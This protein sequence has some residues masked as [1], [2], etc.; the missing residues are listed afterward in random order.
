[1]LLA[2]VTLAVAALR[3]LELEVMDN[4]FPH[5]NETNV[6]LALAGIHRCCPDDVPRPS[7]CRES[8]HHQKGARDFADVV[9]YL[10]NP[11]ILVLEVLLPHRRDDPC[12]GGGAGNLIDFGLSERAEMRM[13]RVY[14]W[15]QRVGSAVRSGLWVTWVVI[16]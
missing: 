11:I 13:N 9:A 16:R 8:L 6:G 10:R 12:F 5:R 1:M 4:P 14:T 15:V 3:I 7:L 2:G